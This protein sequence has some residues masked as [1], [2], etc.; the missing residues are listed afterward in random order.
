MCA[1]LR[2][3]Q[4]V[5]AFVNRLNDH[6]ATSAEAINSLT[7]KLRDCEAA[8][9]EHVESR[10]Q[11][12]QAETEPEPVKQLTPPRS[13]LRGRN[14]EVQDA[15]PVVSVPQTIPRESHSNH[16]ENPREEPA[17]NAPGT[18]VLVICYN[19][20]DYLRKTLNSLL[21][22]EFCAAVW[23]DNF[24]AGLALGLSWRS[25][26]VVLLRLPCMLLA[27]AAHHR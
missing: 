17:P 19:R 6:K 21:R 12:L 26:F 18:A 16:Q 4:S 22:Y 9:K 10:A 25:W 3:L 5:Q 8:N 23:L 1:V 2:A 20:P 27:A 11:R 7:Q 14:G 24:R 15:R 13:A